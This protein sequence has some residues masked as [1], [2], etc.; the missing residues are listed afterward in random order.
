M[1]S[2]IYNIIKYPLILI[3]IKTPLIN[4]LKKRFCINYFFK[5]KNIF[6]LLLDHLFQKE[7]FDKLKDKYEIRKLTDSAL[8]NE[9]GV[10][11]ASHYYDIHFKSLKGLQEKQ[12]GKLKLIDS[13]PIF[14]KIISFIKENNL[15]N[16]KNTYIIQLGSSSGQDIV[17]FLNQF[18][19]L[20]YISTD[21]NKEILDFQ[22][23]KY[24]YPNLKF[25][26]CY[27]EEIEKCIN[28]F[29][30]SNKNL[31]IFSD[32]SLQYVNPFFLDEFFLKIKNYKML[33]LFIS[34]PVNLKF[35]YN[36]KNLMSK[37]RTNIS[38]SHRYDDY[39]KKSK[40]NIIEN[41]LIEPYSKDD[42]HGEVGSSYLH[43]SSIDK[44]ETRNMI[45]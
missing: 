30:I 42:E 8:K 16:H 23:K 41:L 20:N 43:V 2:I 34:E 1:R 31:I 10:N 38:F 19:N 21:I 25:F 17:F 7:Y 33:N 11:W 26:Q 44:D 12:S 9:N 45:D 15:E 37:S 5:K 13:A 14:K 28:E 35:Y 40:N 27:A 32:G 4:I 39:A 29:N 22:K 6:W 3:F 24:N 36:E 18:P